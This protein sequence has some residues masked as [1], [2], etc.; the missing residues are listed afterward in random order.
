MPPKKN[1]DAVQLELKQWNTFETPFRSA[2]KGRLK[3]P[4]KKSELQSM[5]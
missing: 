2:P 4:A 1:K 5:I 3:E